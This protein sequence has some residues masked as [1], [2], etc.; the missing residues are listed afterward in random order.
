LG[1]RDRSQEISTDATELRLPYPITVYSFT[2]GGGPSN[3]T[4]YRGILFNGRAKC[5]V[6][7]EGDTG[8][9]NF[10]DDAGAYPIASVVVGSVRM[11]CGRPVDIDEE[12][13]D[14]ENTDD[15]YDYEDEIIREKSGGGG[16]AKLNMIMLICSGLVSW[17]SS[18]S[19]FI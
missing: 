11:G 13:S 8:P 7:S 15:V 19:F 18:R 3:W 16:S 9:L 14:M 10:M 4:L 12:Y 1:L 2:F 6:Y 17:F 5:L